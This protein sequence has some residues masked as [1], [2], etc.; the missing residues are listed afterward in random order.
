MEV[1]THEGSFWTETWTIVSMK[2][3]EDVFRTGRKGA[4]RVKWTKQLEL[5]NTIQIELPGISKPVSVISPKMI[6]DRFSSQIKMQFHPSWQ[7]LRDALYD[8]TKTDYTHR[9]LSQIS[10]YDA[11]IWR[12]TGLNLEMPN[13]AEDGMWEGDFND[14]KGVS[15]HEDF[16]KEDGE[17]YD[18]WYHWGESLRDVIAIELR[19]FIDDEK[20][21]RSYDGTPPDPETSLQKL[22]DR[23][24][25][26]QGKIPKQ[27]PPHY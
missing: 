20:F 17:K 24:R 23:V 5:D 13:G 11:L 14:L 25:A 19:D 21:S 2:E 3:A 16:W 22:I 6:N 8:R 9:E 12:A 26:K 10:Q 7:K 1:V 15:N 18:V 27:T 4:Y